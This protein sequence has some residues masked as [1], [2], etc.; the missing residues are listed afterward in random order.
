MIRNS[1]RFQDIYNNMMK[2]DKKTKKDSV[3]LVELDVP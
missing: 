2:D 1:A 3:D